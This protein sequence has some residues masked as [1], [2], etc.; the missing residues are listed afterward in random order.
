LAA[1]RLQLGAVRPVP[2]RRLLDRLRQRRCHGYPSGGLWRGQDGK[3]PQGRLR[4]RP[5]VG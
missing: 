4:H 5:A 3:R 1:L 2:G